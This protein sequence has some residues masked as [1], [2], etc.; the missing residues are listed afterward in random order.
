M[1]ECRVGRDACAVPTRALAGVVQEWVDR[2][3][4]DHPEL[5]AAK[6][7]A[8]GR[9][10]GGGGS[11]AHR[12]ERGHLT[13]N[14]ALGALTVLHERTVMSDPTERG[15]SKDT[16]RHVLRHR[17]STYT[18]LRTADLLISAIQRPEVFHDGTLPI[19]PNPA[20]TSEA[21]ASCCG[22]SLTGVVSPA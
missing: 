14:G 22:G 20:A 21:R 11:E 9:R 16:I 1:T 3:D 17:R 12:N 8:N 6:R 2:W 13:G 10:I 5:A 18:E 15:V 4:R 19:V 7:Q